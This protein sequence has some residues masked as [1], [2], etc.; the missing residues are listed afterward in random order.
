MLVGN[1]YGMAMQHI[2]V[3][4]EDLREDQSTENPSIQ[5]NTKTRFKPLL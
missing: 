5:Q 2:N 3:E 4:N 1:G